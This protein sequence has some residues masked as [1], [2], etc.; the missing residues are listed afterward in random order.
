MRGGEWENRSCLHSQK[1]STCAT[2]FYKLSE[3]V[4]F[5]DH[6]HYTD[7]M[8]TWEGR[9]DLHLPVLCFPVHFS[10][11]LWMTKILPGYAYPYDLCGYFSPSNFYSFLQLLLDVHWLFWIYFS[12]FSFCV[13]LCFNIQELIACFQD[14]LF[15]RHG[16]LPNL[17]IL[18][19]ILKFCFLRQL[20]CFRS[21]SCYL[22]RLEHLSHATDFCCLSPS[23]LI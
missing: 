16:V 1:P 6:P 5:I 22:F 9:A 17:N 21:S 15:N 7:E 2:S 23:R 4:M 18:I 3:K 14:S 20:R 10:V 11:W 13:L 8:E 19:L 12:Y